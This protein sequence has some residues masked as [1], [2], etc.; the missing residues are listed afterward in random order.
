ME[1]LNQNTKRTLVVGRGRDTDAEVNR[2]QV[3]IFSSI[4]SGCKSTPKKMHWMQS[5]IQWIPFLEKGALWMR[6]RRSGLIWNLTKKHSKIQ[7]RDTKHWKRDSRQII[8]WA[9]PATSGPS[10][11]SV[12]MRAPRSH[13]GPRLRFWTIK[14]ELPRHWHRWLQH[15]PKYQIHLKKL[16][17]ILKRKETRKNVHWNRFGLFLSDVFISRFIVSYKYSHCS[18]PRYTSGHISTW[19]GGWGESWNTIFHCNVI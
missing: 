10:Y 19:C 4:D 18:G 17:Q 14:K 7:T 12:S 9:V 3:V 2:K 8:V 5:H 13:S 11:N 6:L 16:I 1:N 15:L